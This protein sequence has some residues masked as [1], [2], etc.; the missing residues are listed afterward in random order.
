[1]LINFQNEGRLGNKMFAF[2]FSLIL[3]RK[4]DVR[5]ISLP[6]P[7]FPTTNL[8][9]GWPSR[10]ILS[11]PVIVSDSRESMTEILQRCSGKTVFVRGWFERVEFYLHELTLLRSTFD[12]TQIQQFDCV[13]HF[14]GKDFVEHGKESPVEFYIEA[15]RRLGSPRCPVICTDDLECPSMLKFCE[16]TGTP[17]PT[18]IRDKMYDFNL[19]RSAKS[20]IISRSTFAWWAGLLSFGNVIQPEYKETNSYRNLIVPT[21]TQI[22]I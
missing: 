6:L 16:I 9:T 20:L 10:T 15:W 22:P 8:Y 3:A 17:K 7:E 14:R 12:Y 19:M 4:L 13:L 5:L 1:M 18:I 11:D 2:A 21:W